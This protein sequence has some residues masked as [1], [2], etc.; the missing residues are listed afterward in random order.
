MKTSIQSLQ[1]RTSSRPDAAT[2]SAAS[3]TVT[4]AGALCGAVNPQVAVADP[5]TQALLNPD[6][7]DARSSLPEPEEDIATASSDEAK[8]AEQPLDM[9]ALME[10][11]A[12]LMNDERKISRDITHENNKA[13]VD[14]M[15]ASAAAM[16]KAAD[17]EFTG[18][19]LLAGATFLSGVVNIGGAN[20]KTGGLTDTT[21][22]LRMQWT[23]GLG[24]VLQSGGQAGSGTYN[25]YAGQRKADSSE[26]QAYS[27]AADKFSSEQQGITQDVQSMI[28]DVDAK[29]KEM[30]DAKDQSVKSITNNI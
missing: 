3:Q 5:L 14:A 30:F 25:W 10:M 7:G 28:R 15:L 2:S 24:S 9:F 22:K 16:G 17:D 26:D 18:A 19:M 6:S 29:L 21:A 27:S 11:L 13:S 4:S 23:Q 8:V 12:R 20:L 1:P